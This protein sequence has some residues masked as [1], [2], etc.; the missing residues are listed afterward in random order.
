MPLGGDRRRW[1][2]LGVAFVVV[3]GLAVSATCA[4]DGD[5][6]VVLTVCVGSWAACTGIAIWLSRVL[7][8]AVQHVDGLADAYRVERQASEREAKRRRNARLLHDTVLATLTLLAHSGHGV[9][10]GPL[11]LQAAEDAALLRGLRL[12]GVPQPAASGDYRLRTGQRP[13][14]N[15]T[16][17]IVRQRFERM[18]LEVSW[19]GTGRLPLP[20]DALHALLLALTECLENVRRHAGT[21]Q[22]HVT[23]TEDARAVH[24][25]VTD[26][27]I[28]F[29]PGAVPAARLG[30]AES[31]VSRIREVGGS[32]RLF[33]SP[34]LG[35]T[36]A[37]EVPKAVQ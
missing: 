37:I 34:G 1:P 29:D 9:S 21:A 16:L 3:T 22:A 27:G 10:E 11:R 12:G 2:V 18:G 15:N 36:V 17:E 20:R 24:A 19:H 5:P 8:Q 23:I 33:S 6:V 4:L 28:G 7:P 25:V 14:P 13:T 30:Y 31:V 32:V 26:S 35:T